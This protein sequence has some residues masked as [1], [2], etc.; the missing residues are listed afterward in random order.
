MPQKKIF[1]ENLKSKFEGGRNSPAMRN[2]LLKVETKL[3]QTF[4]DK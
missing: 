1:G 3:F 4:S 2:G